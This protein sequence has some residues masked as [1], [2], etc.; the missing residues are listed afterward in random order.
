MNTNIV[1]PTVPLNLSPLP[2]QRAINRFA[3]CQSF[4]TLFVALLAS[5]ITVSVSAQ[6]NPQ[7]SFLT[8]GLVAYYPFN[9]NANDAS[10]NGRHGTQ[11]LGNFITNRF[12][13]SASAFEIPAG[14]SGWNW[15]VDSGISDNFSDSVTLALWFKT[16]EGG[17]LITHGTAGYIDPYISVS[18]DQLF[19]RAS[20]P[21]NGLDYRDISITDGKWH[22]VVATI[23]GTTDHL[24]FD[25][26]L[27][28]TGNNPTPASSGT[29][30]LGP[31]SSGY[32]DV[33]IYN[34]ALSSNEV[35]QLY[36]YESQ[37]QSAWIVVQISPTFQN[38]VW[39]SV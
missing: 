6:T 13:N 29:W 3:A 9:G 19:F 5:L 4:I 26:R 33:R 12:G 38:P 24:Y 1:K 32:D 36:A 37:P 10:G 16:L 2:P 30:K 31:A 14:N 23:S 27:V 28:A 15:G 20:A 22:S 18:N 8:N 17:I 11:L 34:R 35:A 25:G 21:E 7:P 39:T